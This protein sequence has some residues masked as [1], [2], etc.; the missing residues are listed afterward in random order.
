LDDR[1]AALDFGRETLMRCVDEVEPWEYG[2][3]VR[4]PALDRVWSLN[5]VLV[6]RPAPGLTFDDLDGLLTEQFGGRRFA[7]A[8]FEDEAT[9]ERLEPAA[10]ERGW[11]VEHELVMA[12][13]RDPD[14]VVDTSSVREATEAQLMTL[15]SRWFAEDHAKDG[16]EMLRQLDEYG[17]REWKARGGRAFV[18]GEGQAMCE[19]Y[20]EGGVMQVEGVY[21]APEARGRG[22]A[23]VVVTHALAV[24]RA[25]DPDLVFLVADADGTPKDLYTR[26]GFDPLARLTR[27]VR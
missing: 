19:L 25:G 9:A 20:S 11:K 10:R 24:A 8:V 14:R 26:L 17:R 21:T 16:P 6:E 3:I 1:T 12:L 13:R 15:L 2:R 23:R 18:A 7:G 4:T 22:L 5:T 27:V